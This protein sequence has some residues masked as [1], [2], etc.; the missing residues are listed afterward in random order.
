MFIKQAIT[1]CSSLTQTQ[2][3]LRTQHGMTASTALQNIK[4]CVF[5]QFKEHTVTLLILQQLNSAI[6]YLCSS[7]HVPEIIWV[8]QVYNK[9]NICWGQF[10]SEALRE[11]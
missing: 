7:R 8:L 9:I 11:F 5:I 3:E 4:Y 6:N 10:F 1:E 2:R